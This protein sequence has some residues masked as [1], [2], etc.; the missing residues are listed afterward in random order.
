MANE[1]MKKLLSLVTREVQIKTMRLTTMWYPGFGPRTTTKGISG[2]I[3]GNPNKSCRL[4]NSIIT[5]LM[6]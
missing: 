1:H 5:M 4:V 2:K 3:W 6:S